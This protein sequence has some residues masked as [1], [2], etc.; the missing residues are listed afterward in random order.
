LVETRGVLLGGDHHQSAAGP[1]AGVVA[2]STNFH[3]HAIAACG[4]RVA[5]VDGRWLR[6]FKTGDIARVE[7]DGYFF[8]STAT[9]TRARSR[10]FSTSTPTCARPP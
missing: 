8:M 9:Y 6:W 5:V 2:P 7:E 10:K 1:L 4:S 3:I